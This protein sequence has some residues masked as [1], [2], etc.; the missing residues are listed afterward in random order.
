MINN[1][2]RGRIDVAVRHRHFQLKRWLRVSTAG[3]A[4][5]CTTHGM[6]WHFLHG[7]KGEKLIE[8][9]RNDAGNH[10]FPPI[11]SIQADDA[12]LRRS[13]ACQ[14]AS[15]SAMYVGI[16][17]SVDRGRCICQTGGGRAEGQWITENWE[18]SERRAVIKVLYT[19]GAAQ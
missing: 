11:S 10:D 19:C 17:Y 18:P 2:A 4:A 16:N 9:S 14:S 7:W 5:V 15:A 1:N 13:P 3:N 12:E 6:K 8:Q